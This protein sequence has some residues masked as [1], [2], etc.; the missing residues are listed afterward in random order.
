MQ[1]TAGNFNPAECFRVQ[2]KLL[3]RLSMSKRENLFLVFLFALKMCK[4]SIYNREESDTFCS[5][6]IYRPHTGCIKFPLKINSEI[7]QRTYCNIFDTE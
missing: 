5:G 7:F 1:K 4:K 2:N 6:I 3:K